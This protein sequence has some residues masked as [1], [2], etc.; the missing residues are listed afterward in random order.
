VSRVLVATSKSTGKEIISGGKG[1]AKRNYRLRSTHGTLTEYITDGKTGKG[2]GRYLLRKR[3]SGIRDPLS[4]ATATR[5]LESNKGNMHII[6]KDNE[7]QRR[8]RTS[9]V[10]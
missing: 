4:E 6:R 2:S 3:G 8:G 10:A 5:A 7:T 1:V 9:Y